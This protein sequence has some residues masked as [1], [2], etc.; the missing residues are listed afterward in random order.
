M[1]T[2]LV[3]DDEMDIRDLMQVVLTAEGYETLLAGNGAIA[4]EIMH[5]RKP[6]VV[7]LDMMMPVMDGWTF[8]ERQLAD[9]RVADVPVIGVTAV[10][11]P[12]L[13]SEQLRIPCL[14]KPVNMDA[15][16][17]KVDAACRP[18]TT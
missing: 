2:V 13:V 15:L 4:L 3:V 9:P 5:E 11:D 8:R 17:Q 6:N 16:L 18:R 12:R 7:L 14:G 10:Y 1:P